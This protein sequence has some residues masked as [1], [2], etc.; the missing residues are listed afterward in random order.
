MEINKKIVSSNPVLKWKRIF[1]SQGPQPRPRHGHRAV[2]IKD[3]LIIFGGG[4]EGI[5]D[6]LHVYNSTKNQWFIP[7]VFGE[8]PH[9]CASYGLIADKTRLIIFGGMIEYGNYSNDIYELQASS[10]Q[11]RKLHPKPPPY[12]MPPCPRIGHSFTLIGNKIYLFGGLANDGND[13][14]NNLPRYLND[15]YILDISTPNALSWDIP[16]TVG[17][18]P[19]PRESHTAVGYT[20]SKGKSKLIIYGGMSGQRVGDIWILDIDTM[21]WNKPII[22]G[23]KP[24]PRSL[25]SAVIINNCMFVFGG[26]VPLN[27]NDI[28]E[29]EWKCTNQLASL[30]LETMSWEKINMGMD[31]NNIV[32]KARA[33]HCA[34][35]IQTRMYVWS[36]RDGYKKKSNNQICCSD[37]WYL[38]VDKPQKCVKNQLIRASTNTLEIVWKNISTADAYIV[39]IQKCDQSDDLTVS[40]SQTITDDAFSLFPFLKSEANNYY[41]SS[42]ILHTN[43]IIQ[44]SPQYSTF[45]FSSLIQDQQ[46]VPITVQA[47]GN[48][49]MK[50]VQCTNITPSLLQNVNVISSVMPTTSTFVGSSLLNLPSDSA[51]HTLA[52]AAIAASKIETTVVVSEHTELPNPV[53]KISNTSLKVS[54]PQ[55]TINNV[56]FP[57]N[58]KNIQQDIRKTDLTLQTSVGTVIKTGSNVLGKNLFFKKPGAIKSN[59]LTLVKT[60]QGN[61]I[62]GVS[63]NMTG[64]TTQNKNMQKP[65]LKLINS[66]INKKVIPISTNRTT[67]T[68]TLNTVD[69]RLPVT[70][71]KPTIIIQKGNINRPKSPKIKIVTPVSNLRSIQKCSTSQVNFTN[72]TNV[73]NVP[74]RIQTILPSGNILTESK[75]I[76]ITMAGTNNHNIVTFGQSNLTGMK[77]GGKNITFKMISAN[78]NMGT[79]TSLSDVIQLNNSNI[80]DINA[81][82]RSE[83]NSNMPSTVKVSTDLPVSTESA[84]TQLALEA[85]IFSPPNKNTNEIEELMDYTEEQLGNVIEEEV[86]SEYVY[87]YDVTGAENTLTEKDI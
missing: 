27:E 8:I 86:E 13:P 35:T 4:N 79:F 33:G 37:F 83:L 74:N 34:V 51:M 19:P 85:G 43:K 67:S 11:W 23:P 20:D 14:Q 73:T 28:I 15:L 72:H 3:L 6:E 9:G 40:T 49:K 47:S 52:A 84:L 38:E 71:I 59:F 18:Y 54:Q 70:A 69:T 63:G 21:S 58:T 87:M 24:L 60:N 2:S 16:E 45:N 75:P 65:V 10:W 68:V 76:T 39:Q 50:T 55:K 56:I 82:H 80:M 26:W 78:N 46:F 42:Q 44:L 29:R 32:P 57:L 61:L 7:K 36:G 30:N 77:I 41:E 31:E 48:M 62:Q 5:V 17:D 1:D 66:E 81:T 12:Y 22:L 25:H 53:I 64:T